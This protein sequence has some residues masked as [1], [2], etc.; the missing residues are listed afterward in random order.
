[1][2]TAQPK[3]ATFR[4]AAGMERWAT[5]HG[6]PFNIDSTGSDATYGAIRSDRALLSCRF[7]DG[8]LNDATVHVD[9]GPSHQ[10]GG[11][12]TLPILLRVLVQ[13]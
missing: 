5:A 11:H 1:M 2:T 10:L 4:T 6:L 8:A 3:P 9:N 13:S 12:N 7:V